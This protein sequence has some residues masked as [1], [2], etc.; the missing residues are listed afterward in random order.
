MPERV[1]FRTADDVE[2]IGD[3]VTAPTTMGAAILLPMLPA[4]RQSWGAFQQV[5]SRRGLASVAIDLRG[6]GESV[7]GPGGAVL[8][9]K[10]FTE[11]EHQ[12]SLQDVRGAFEWLRARGIDRPRIVLAGA[13]IG[14]NLALQF[15]ADE[16]QLPAAVL[17]SPGEEY[18]GVATFD[19]A[20]RVLPHQ[21]VWM[22]ASAGDD[23]GSV[24][25][26]DQLEKLL[27]VDEKQVRRLTNA[28]H[29]TRLFETD[30]SLMDHAAD[31][32]RDR[33]LTTS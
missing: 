9:Y 3:W 15:L 11:E 22:A 23:D 21:S 7:R 5:L 32:L 33:M 28:G 4:L 2:I 12:S 29:G 13:S 1:S 25:S 31:W 20:E 10:K 14:A 26:M 17:L 24:R 19:A 18:H 27:S 16:P 6:H 30:A 8:D